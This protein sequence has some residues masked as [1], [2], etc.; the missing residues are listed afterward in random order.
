[1][2]WG[3]HPCLHDRFRGGQGLGAPRDVLAHFVADPVAV[4]IAG[5][6]QALQ[7]GVAVGAYVFEVVAERHVLGVA[8]C[9]CFDARVVAQGGLVVAFPDL[10]HQALRGRADAGEVA[11]AG[12]Q[13][14][15]GAG[16][17]GRRAQRGQQWGGGAGQQGQGSR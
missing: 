10:V 7:G 11:G 8:L 4:H 16:G 5:S 3:V 12:D 2:L 17:V 13:G 15:V 6:A 9:G 1:M 14:C